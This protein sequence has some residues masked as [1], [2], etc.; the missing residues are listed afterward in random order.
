[1]ISYSR[2]LLSRRIHCP[3]KRYVTSVGFDFQGHLVTYNFRGMGERRV[4]PRSPWIIDKHCR[5]AYE[6]IN[7]AQTVHVHGVSNGLCL[8]TRIRSVS[9]RLKLEKS[10]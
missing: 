9:R 5:D 6:E 2:N 3:A 8:T 4:F 10:R 7:D 1:M